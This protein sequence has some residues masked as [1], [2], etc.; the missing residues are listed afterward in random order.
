M[1]SLLGIKIMQNKEYNEINGIK[2]DMTKVR[3]D[4]IEVKTDISWIKEHLK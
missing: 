3:L 2:Q 4:M 1:I